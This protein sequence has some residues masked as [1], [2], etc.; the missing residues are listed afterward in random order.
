MKISETQKGTNPSGALVTA[1]LRKVFILLSIFAVAM[2]FMEGIAVVYLRQLYYPHG[3]DFPLSLLTPEMHCIELIR[4]T[5]TLVMLVTV[6]W[7]AGRTFLQRLSFFLF[8]FAVW[9]IFYY[10][11]LKLILDWPSSWF[12]WDI[13]F[14]IPVPWIGPVLAPVICSLTMILISLLFIWLPHKGYPLRLS[15]PDWI[16]LLSGSGIIFYTFIR[17]FL[18]LFIRNSNISGSLNDNGNF[19]ELITTFVPSGYNWMLFIAG[20][21]ILISVSVLMIRRSVLK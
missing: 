2:G 18:I 17:D 4:E 3:F 19:R 14:L 21:I 6:A 8:T 16:L 9:D 5:A 7:I 13:L 12:S 10:V 1:N 15:L 11:A 20:E